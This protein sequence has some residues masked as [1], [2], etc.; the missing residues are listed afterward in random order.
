MIDFI[1]PILAAVM[2]TSG[3]SAA[4][5]EQQAITKI[6][7]YAQSSTNPKPTL[8]DYIAAGVDGVDKNNIN[9]YNHLVDSLE[10][11][12]VDSAAERASLKD[13]FI[14]L[15]PIDDI[16]TTE[17]FSPITV[18][19]NI[20]Y[21]GSDI[22]RYF[23]EN[24]NSAL[25]NATVDGKGVI[26]ITSTG[27]G[28]G[29]GSSRLRLIVF[30]GTDAHNAEFTVTVNT[31]SSESMAFDP[32]AFTV[33]SDALWDETAVRKVLYAFAYGGHATDTQIRTWA[34]MPPQ[35][36]IVQ[37]LT[38]EPKNKLLSPSAYILPNTVSLE[39]LAKFW[40]TA[41]YVKSEK[42]KYFET[43]PNSWATPSY[44][45]IMAVMSRGLNPF[46]HRVGLWE[47]NYHMS[48]SQESGVYPLPMLTYYDTIMQQ[49]RDN[50]SYEQVMASGAKSAAVAFQYGHNYNSYKNGLFR[51]NEDFAREY[52]QLFFGILGNYDHNY[53]ENTTIP[54]TARALTDMKALWHP[55]AEGGPERK[56]TFGTAEHYSA[57][58]DILKTT[59][60]G[61]RADVKLDAIATEAIEHAES[62]NNLP[63]MIIKHF[64]DDTPSAGTIN[65]A[66]SSWA[67]MP[68]KRLLPF[69]WAYAVSTDFHNPARIKYANSIQRLVT[70]INL[71]TIDND[72]NGRMLYNANWELSKE[73]IRPFRPV[74]AVFGHQTGVEASDNGNIFRINYNRSAKSGWTYW[75]YYDCVKNSS[76]ECPKDSNGNV[77]GVWEKKWR[78]KIPTNGAGEYVVEDVARWLWERFIADGG[79]HYGP[80]ERAHLIALLNGKDLALLLDE[81]NPLKVYTRADI[82]T[83]NG[84][85]KLLNDA[86]VARMDLKSGDLKKRRSADYR[87]NLAISFIA[88]TPYIY[89]QEGR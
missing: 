56:I 39:R 30:T 10:G 70:T 40:N 18:R 76:G 82:T 44:S 17:Y 45:W 37:M 38:F 52:Y 54:N 26:T 66:R 51:G 47:T 89:A 34:A 87:V 11:S 43:K 80:L 81:Q 73:D 69:L 53:H 21:G 42:K 72:E 77:I 55:I 31:I 63:V 4:V 15:K 24:S 83:N 71:M 27:N 49:L 23:L 22:V 2:S 19:A 86:A 64:A 74:H 60:S 65:R 1:A 7:A 48:V 12:D 25:I 9:A 68:Q 79:K 14:T 13:Y 88:A 50:R 62:L 57:D 46:V 32:L 59:V 41:K 28:S 29:T 33:V 58:I 20:S 35:Q 8:Q 67:M 36:A 61:Y 85:K 84:I 16:V 78:D 75:Q 5:Q 3:G 6:I